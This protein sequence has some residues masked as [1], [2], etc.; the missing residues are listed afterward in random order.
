MIQ[1]MKIHPVLGMAVTPDSR[2]AEHN[3][4]W[5]FSHSSSKKVQVVFEQAPSC[6]LELAW[7]A[8]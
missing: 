7:T 6:A 8:H 1:G 2:A 4:T 3:P 5:D